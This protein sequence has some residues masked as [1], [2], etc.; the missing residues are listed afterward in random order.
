MTPT[1]LRAAIKQLSQKGIFTEDN[2]MEGIF[3]DLESHLADLEKV[4]ERSRSEL[5]EGSENWLKASYHVGQ[6]WSGSWLISHA[7]LYFHGFSKPNLDQRF[8][9]EWGLVHGVPDG[10]SDAS[11]D[12]VFEAI[13]VHIGENAP[14]LDEV[15]Q[16]GATLEEAVNEYR[17]YFLA[18]IQ[19]M[20]S[21]DGF[22]SES[23][24]VLGFEQMSVRQGADRFLTAHRPDSFFTRDQA[25]FASGW[26]A[27]YHLCIAARASSALSVYTG[28][29]EC[30]RLS[31]RIVEQ[32][33]TKYSIS[34]GGDE[35][36]QAL[37]RVERL[38]KKFHSV[39]RQL[40]IRHAGRPTIEVNDEYDVQDILH[41]LLRIDFEDIR[42]EEWT[43]SYAG[44]SSRID[45]LLNDS[46]IAIE[47]KK[48]R[49]TLKDKDI[50]EQL[51][52]DRV[53]Y[54]ASER[55]RTL[56]C[57]IY[58]PEGKIMNPEGLKKDLEDLSN[59]ELTIV[60]FVEPGF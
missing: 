46:K 39:A 2:L 13:A 48:T 35:A 17:D 60:V 8:D 21:Q 12:E 7:D 28:A 26:K 34:A 37:A 22:E 6:A 41:S 19:P 45:F 33:K 58:D 38:L 57:F 42:P 20:V 16:S 44:G 47:V 27:P 51:I 3:N 31:K 50:G 25:A 40:R 32:L 53:R 55:C 9:C 18:K 1:R 52:I 49:D 15:E 30:V 36:L 10:W 24:L 43:P 59:D 5:V 4:M 14:T 11:E 56:V 54:Q 29:Q 23:K